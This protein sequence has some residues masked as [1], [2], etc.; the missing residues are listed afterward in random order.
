MIMKNNKIS[1]VGIGPGS[2]DYILPIAL[3]TIQKAKFLVG[4]KRA[5]LEYAQSSQKTCTIAAD[6][7]AVIEFI[8]HNLATN[9]VV[10]MVSGDP[11]FHSMLTCLKKEFVDTPLEVI[12]GIGSLQMAFSKINL[13]WQN[14]D[15]FSLHGDDS[16]LQ[17]LN[18]KTGLVLAMLTDR[19]N[20]PYAISQYL[21]KGGW[22]KE[23]QMFI[24]VN[25]SYP[26]EQIISLPLGEVTRENIYENCVVIITE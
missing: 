22:Q 26:D 17:R 25:L 13:P 11:C 9:D 2:R 24:C 20:N 6:I 7:P 14:A 8:K 23:H 15:M 1:V 19:K 12:S 3:Q 5:L 18:Y 4:G 21:L 10:V 16:N